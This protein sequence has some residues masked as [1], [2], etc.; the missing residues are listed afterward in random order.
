M[1][2]NSYAFLFA[3]LPLAVAGFFVLGKHSAR[4]AAGWLVASSLFF[5][6]FWNP[7]YVGLLLASILFNFTLGARLARR[8]ASARVDRRTVALGVAAN[9][10]VLGYFKYANFFVDNLNAIGGTSISLQAIVL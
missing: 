9:L 7:V 8:P 5:Y 6:A 10:V 1:L 2:F 4:S 3:F